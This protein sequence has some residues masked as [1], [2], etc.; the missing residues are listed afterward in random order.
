[1]NSSACLNTAQISNLKRIYQPWWEANNTKI[2]DG[3]QPGGEAG[4]EFLFNGATPQFG[5][6]FFRNAVVNDSSWDYFTMDA[7][8][9]AL[10]D[11]INP[12]G[13]NAYDPDLR[14]FQARKGKVMEYHGFQDPIIPSTASGT[15]YDKVLGFYQDLNQT[16]E[17][18]DFYRLFM[19][20]G[21][22]HCNGGDGGTLLFLSMFTETRN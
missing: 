13:I 16:N 8:T 17:V 1:M 15:W 4:F 21:M 14:P 18:E 9:V 3:L 10:A 7:A 20:P 11:S 22:E 5:I 12:G 2:F 19:V 6:D